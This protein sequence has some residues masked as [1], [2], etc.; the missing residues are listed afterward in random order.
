MASRHR[1]HNSQEKRVLAIIR[2]H[3]DR[4]GVNETARILGLDRSTVSRRLAGG[5]LQTWSIADLVKLCR[6]RSGDLGSQTY[7]AIGRVLLP[8]EGS[9]GGRF[10]REALRAVSQLA[11]F[12]DHLC[13]G[14][15]MRDRSS[16][17][18]DKIRI[19]LGR[20]IRRFQELIGEIDRL[21]KTF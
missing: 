14:V 8:E 11:R 13:E 10:E 18:L 20:M 2:D 21:K 19:E 7:H 1:S 3:V 9:F 17:E 12:V 4:L 15:L 5:Q 6:S 16:A